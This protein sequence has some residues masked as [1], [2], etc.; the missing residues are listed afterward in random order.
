MNLNERNTDTWDES[1]TKLF[2]EYV[3]SI[4]KGSKHAKETNE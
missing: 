2:T 3:G 1:K 4:K